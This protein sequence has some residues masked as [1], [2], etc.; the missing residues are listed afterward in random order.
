MDQVERDRHRK[1]HQLMIFVDW[2]VVCSSQLIR[3]P[4]NGQLILRHGGWQCNLVPLMLSGGVEDT[5]DLRSRTLA[6]KTLHDILAVSRERRP[7][8]TGG[9]PKEPWTPETMLASNIKLSLNIWVLMHF[10]HFTSS[11]DSDDNLCQLLH[12]SIDAIE[13]QTGWIPQTILLVRVLLVSLLTKIN[14]STHKRS[15]KQGRRTPRAA[16]LSDEKASSRCGLG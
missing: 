14:S 7:S 15:V 9:S 13:D 1:L 2:L 4:E 10:T 16:Q 3:L 12:Q 5:L 8:V 11:T 6:S